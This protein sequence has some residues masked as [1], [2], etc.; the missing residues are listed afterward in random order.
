M[1]ISSNVI[2]TP[3][4]VNKL[5][6][7]LNLKELEM[8]TLIRLG[9][10][11]RLNRQLER[12]NQHC[13]EVLHIANKLGDTLRAN[14]AMGVIEKLPPWIAYKRMMATHGKLQPRS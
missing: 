10:A 2:C 7:N 12:A 9:H 11:H 8:D 14:K 13:Q 6:L 3:N 1:N 4:S 5:N